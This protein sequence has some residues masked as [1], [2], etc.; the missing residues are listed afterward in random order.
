MENKKKTSYKLFCKN[1]MKLDKLK[2]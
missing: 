1:R 2:K